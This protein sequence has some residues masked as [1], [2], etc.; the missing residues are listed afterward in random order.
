M[1]GSDDEETVAALF[2]TTRE[3]AKYDPMHRSRLGAF[4]D[5]FDDRP[6]HVDRDPAVA[7]ELYLE[8]FQGGAGNAEAGLA[9]LEA[10]ARSPE[11][12]GDPAAAAVRVMAAGG[13]RA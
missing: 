5:P 7:Y 3:L 8:A 6:T 12:A 11:A 13:G 10:W 4:Y 1:E 2:Y 9:R